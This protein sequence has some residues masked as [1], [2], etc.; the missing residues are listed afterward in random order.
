[1]RNTIQSFSIS[2]T[3]ERL[4][5]ITMRCKNHM[6]KPKPKPKPIQIKKNLRKENLPTTVWK[7]KMEGDRSNS[8]D[9]FLRSLSPTVSA[10]HQI[11]LCL[12]DAL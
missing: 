6:P 8:E 10:S 1:M 11:S 2:N 12:M 5:E 3:N 4:K 7:R 9:G